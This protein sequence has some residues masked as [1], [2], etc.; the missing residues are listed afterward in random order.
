[1]A[2]IRRA[3]ALL[4]L[5]AG[6]TL[7][8]CSSGGLGAS[9][10]SKKDSPYAPAA[11]RNAV[12][13]DPLIVGYRLS[14]AGEHELALKSFRR[15]AAD[16]GL[17]TEIISAMASANLGL[18]RLGQSESLLRRATDAE[19]ATSEDWNNLGVVL[20]ERGKT[21]EATHIFRKAFALDNGRSDSIRDNLRIAL[22]KLENVD[23]GEAQEQDYKLVRRG[24]S[25]FLIRKTP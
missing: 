2:Q 8:A 9:L 22:A 16:Q 25:D 3:T 6:L 7:A 17:T 20:M 23:Y 12:G 11:K 4:C 24:T 18:G 14:G 10:G 5:T 1:M 15:A 21:A 13:E 19:D